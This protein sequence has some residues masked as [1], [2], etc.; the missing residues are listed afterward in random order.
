MF[1]GSINKIA[2]AH[3]EVMQNNDRLSD[4]IGWQKYTQKIFRY[5]LGAREPQVWQYFDGKEDM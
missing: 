4:G 5:Q 3:S 1:N 2:F